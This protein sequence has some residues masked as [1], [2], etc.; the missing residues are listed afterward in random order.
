MVEITAEHTIEFGSPSI[1]TSITVS[2]AYLRFRS[3]IAV[4]LVLNTAFFTK[5]LCIVSGSTSEPP[6]LPMKPNQHA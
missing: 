6:L 4:D 3:A 2:P 5:C 1:A